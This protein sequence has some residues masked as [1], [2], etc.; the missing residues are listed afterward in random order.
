M[1]AN[2]LGHDLG[3]V[4]LVPLSLVLSSSSPPFLVGA[5]GCILRWLSFPCP[6][7]GARRGIRLLCCCFWWWLFL[8]LLNFL[9][10]FL[11]GISARGPLSF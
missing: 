3:Q 10:G 5:L 2:L 11:F 4:V 8:L 7:S 6:S 1:S 9:V